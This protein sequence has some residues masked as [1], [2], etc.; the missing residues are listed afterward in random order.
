MA[1]KKTWAELRN[2]AHD[3]VNALIDQYVPSDPGNSALKGAMGRYGYLA[4]RR[5]EHQ[6]HERILKILKN[7]PLYERPG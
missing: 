2:E 3:Y 4:M 6:E 1:P 5:G 7:F